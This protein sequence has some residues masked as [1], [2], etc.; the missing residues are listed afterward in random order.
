MEITSLSTTN[1]CFCKNVNH[2]IHPTLFITTKEEI[3]VWETFLTET[4]NDFFRLKMQEFSHFFFVF[5]FSFTV[6]VV[7]KI[8]FLFRSRDPE[9]KKCHMEIGNTKEE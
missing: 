6:Q 7:K 3:P 2:F 4:V 8:H 1:T 9:N 5:L